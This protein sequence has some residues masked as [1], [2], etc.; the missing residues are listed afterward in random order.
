MAKHLWDIASKKDT[1]WV[2]W[3]HEYMLKGQ[4][5]WTCRLPNDASW[6]WLKIMK[7]RD[8]F[9]NCIRHKIGSGDSIFTW[10]DYWHSD[11]PLVK[12]Y[13]LRIV[14]DAVSTPDSKLS[15]YIT[16]GVWTFPAISSRNLIRI[17]NNLPTIN[18]NTTD[19]VAWAP[20]GTGQFTAVSAKGS[21]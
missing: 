9:H 3:C 20:S 14:Y 13:G 18:H 19:P 11:G 7:L 6:T 12:K 16:E 21:Y 17:A 5:L 4:C 2:K 10:F 15:D 8:S 1:L